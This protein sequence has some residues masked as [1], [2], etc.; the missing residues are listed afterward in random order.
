MLMRLEHGFGAGSSRGGNKY[1]L[2]KVPL[3]G[4]RGL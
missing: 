3:L 1:L 2:E 4:M